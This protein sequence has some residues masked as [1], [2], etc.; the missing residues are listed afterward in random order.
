MRQS[1]DDRLLG[2]KRDG[3]RAVRD[4]EVGDGPAAALTRINVLRELRGDLSGGS[5]EGECD[6]WS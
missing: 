2:D 4:T 5:V 1:G 6:P 3:V